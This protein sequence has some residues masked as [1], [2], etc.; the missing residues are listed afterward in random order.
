MTDFPDLVIAAGADVPREEALA[1][2]QHIGAPL[3]DVP[4]EG[5]TLTLDQSGLSLVGYG[6]RFQGDYT[7][8]L[9]RISGGR[10]NH[11]MLVKIAKTKTEHPVAID[12]AAGMGEDALLLSAAGYTVYLFE[13]DPVIAALLKDTIRRAKQNPEL[14]EIVGRMHL[15]EGD[16]I[17]L[18]ATVP[19]QPE[20]VYLDP[21]FPA[22]R[23]SGLINK[24]LQ[25]IQKLEQPCAQEEELLAAAIA[26]HPRKIVIK[27]PLHSPFLAD[28]KPGYTVKGKAI[29]YD[30]IVL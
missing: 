16:S 24:K 20:L 10:L 4:G 25:L 18:M 23:K 2:S 28:K 17:E 30:V 5:L 9:R 14:K 11:E 3:S 15:T 6:L 8:L 26:V 19:E 13:Q 12:A 27:R 29:R 1:L 22:R 7:E 21:M